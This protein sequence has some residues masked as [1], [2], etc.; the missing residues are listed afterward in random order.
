MSCSM[1]FDF[2]LPL[3]FTTTPRFRRSSK[4]A[5]ELAVVKRRGQERRLIVS[6]G[7]E[8]LA[9][10]IPLY[11]ALLK[12]RFGSIAVAVID[13]SEP[14][15]IRAAKM[16]SAQY[17]LPECFRLNGGHFDHFQKFD[18]HMY[19]K[20]SKYSARRCIKRITLFT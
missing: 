11:E 18:Q 4:A 1:F 10:D 6:T 12:A 14:A 9:S 16:L 13:C 3:E 7:G 2:L 20:N 5:R 8:V 17:P 19:G 15:D